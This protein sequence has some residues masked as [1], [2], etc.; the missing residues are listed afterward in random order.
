MKKPWKNYGGKKYRIS[1]QNKE[2]KLLF[3]QAY[4]GVKWKN[5]INCNQ[6]SQ[7]AKKYACIAAKLK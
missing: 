5:M 3:V 6:N 7:K 4:L 1:P 2:V